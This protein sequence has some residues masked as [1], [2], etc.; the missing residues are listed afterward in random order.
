VKKERFDAITDAVFAIILTLMVLEIKLPVF[1]RG[2]VPM[3]LEQLFVYG[4]S[5][6]T[7]AI[8]WLNHHNMF[9]NAGK[10]ELNLVWTNFFLLFATSLIPLATERLSA[11][12]YETPS[13]VFYGAIL[14]LTAFLY[15]VLQNQE[16]KQ[17]NTELKA[18]V[19][20]INWVGTSLYFTSIPLS[21]ISI[22]LSTMI[23]VLIPTLYFII[24][25]K[26]QR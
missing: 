13:H 3:I 5:F 17:R 16:A 15:S 2:N 7:I 18:S 21:F 8:I 6:V 26:P 25:R 12:F 20:F 23:Y 14:G 4:L 11:G 9:V 10:I 1:N 19:H 22:Y 24:S